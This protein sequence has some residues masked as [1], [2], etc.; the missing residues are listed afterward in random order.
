[1]MSYFYNNNNNGNG[2][3]IP[4][5]NGKANGTG[6]GALVVAP[7]TSPPPARNSN[8]GVENATPLLPPDIYDKRAEAVVVGLAFRD[9]DHYTSLKD[10]GVDA[11]WFF[12]ECHNH[13]WLVLVRLYD[14]TQPTAYQVTKEEVYECLRQKAFN[15]RE[16][17][18]VL[19]AVSSTSF[20]GGG[21][22]VN[23]PLTD[24]Y[25]AF[26]AAVVESG[27]HTGKLPTYF[28]RL[29]EAHKKCLEYQTVQKWSDLLANKELTTEAR[30]AILEKEI[31]T[32]KTAGK[33]SS[34][35]SASQLAGEL[36]EV[37]AQKLADYK[38]GITTSTDTK[39]PWE[40]AGL[41]KVMRGGLGRRQWTLITAPPKHGKTA[42]AQ[43]QVFW[44]GKEKG[45]VCVVFSLEMARQEWWER[46]HQQ[47][48]GIPSYLLNEGKFE[49]L[50]QTVFNNL[51]RF[52]ETK[53][54]L[55]DNLDATTETIRRECEHVFRLEGRIDLVL[56]DY[57][58][59]LKDQ[60]KPG[61]NETQRYVEMSRAMKAIP[62]HFDCHMIMIHS[63]SKAGGTYQSNAPEYDCDNWLDITESPAFTND[64][65][66]NSKSGNAKLTLKYQRYGTSGVPIQLWWN[67]SHVRF[68]DQDCPLPK[69]EMRRIFDDDDYQ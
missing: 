26:N 42:L 47:D 8:S 33:E 13:L 54:Y 24:C 16:G 20:G 14:G 1:M 6:G 38:E 27:S 48:T 57:F 53:I 67:E 46:V 3:V 50:E 15:T 58:G 25:S 10:A 18:T 11:S 32:I 41:N 69:L 44:Y 2:N 65:V 34:L 22:G 59:L 19:P 62:R 21:L 66:T 35:V 49:N 39:V 29:K 51:Y 7:T 61:D 43:R 55:Y 5:R 37:Y 9:V 68:T 12:D 40:L 63:L 36:K 56:V 60:R 30:L 64:G 45:G 4:V 23:L 52:G 17:V 28:N 31:A